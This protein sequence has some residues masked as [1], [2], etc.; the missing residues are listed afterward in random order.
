MTTGGGQMDKSGRN[1]LAGIRCFQ[2][3]APTCAAPT[4]AEPTSGRNALAG[5]GCFQWRNAD[6]RSAFV[7]GAES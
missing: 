1:A 2:S 5:I 4:F 7:T 6:L 3:K